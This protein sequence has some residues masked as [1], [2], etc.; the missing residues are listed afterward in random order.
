M[1]GGEGA[2]LLQGGGREAYAGLLLQL[3]EC[4][5]ERLLAVLEVAA[6]EAPAL[7]VDAGV[8]VALLQQDPAAPVD[9]DH[10]GEATCAVG[11][12]RRVVGGPGPEGLQ[13][14]PGGSD[15]R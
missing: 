2:H 14:L 10:T 11:R 15:E 8:L 5:G 1:V 7:R 12:G 9:Q 13:H 3:A 4:S 6:G